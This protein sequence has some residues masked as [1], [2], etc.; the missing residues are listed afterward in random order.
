MRIVFFTHPPF[1]GSQSMPRFASML[2][3][4]MQQRG[5]QIEVWTPE[6][7]FYKLSAPNSLKKWLGY[8]D[9]YMMFPGQV[10]KRIKSYP[11]QTLF[12][13][14]DHALGPWVPLVANRPH[15]IHC[16]DFLAQQSAFGKIKENP[17]S[18]TGRLYQKFIH[19]GY[20]KGKNF[21]SVSNKTSRDLNE[22]LIKKPQLSDVVYNGLN[23]NF[24]PLEI[25]KSRQVFGK[26]VGIDLSTGFILHIGG[27]Q[28]Y[29]NREGVI[30][31]YESW[32]KLGNGKLPLL[33][34]GKE[35]SSALKQKQEQS[36]FARDI[37][38]LT[39]INDEQTL[40]AYAGATLLLFPSLAEGFGWPIA[41][42]MASGC[43]VVTT[44]EAPMTEVAGNA[45][46]LIKKRDDQKGG[47]N[48]WA[49]EAA[50]VVDRVIN[51]SPAEREI[52]I[53]SGIKNAK[54]FQTENMLN[55]IEE[56]YRFLTKSFEIRLEK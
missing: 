53:E 17:T 10:R 11:G 14:T 51:L 28:W 31:I 23:R 5:H 56:I 1:L 18:F 48:L 36:A 4:G 38:F 13:F 33:L 35:P 26:S 49:D 19:K 44:N 39:D 52:V 32:R 12:V 47:I 34:I 8:L 21:V 54:R 24:K 16:H 3:N 43:P 45:G 29:K 41:E 20:S 55:N 42:A 37:F 40:L 46:F 7:Y 15:V 22:F 50:L 2:A 27:N 9:Q 6:A 25:E 30:E